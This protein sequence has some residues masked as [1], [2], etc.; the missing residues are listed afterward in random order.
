[1]PFSVMMGRCFSATVEGSARLKPRPPLLWGVLVV[2][3]FSGWDEM[4]WDGMGAGIPAGDVQVLEVG[5]DLLGVLVGALAGDGAFDDGVA[6]GFEFI[7][8]VA[9]FSA[10][11]REESVWA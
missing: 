4:G 3:F 11:L 5:E 6:V 2:W 7:A 9:V 8:P 10:G 1:M